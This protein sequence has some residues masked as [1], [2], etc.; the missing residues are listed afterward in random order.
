MYAS[1]N[2]TSETASPRRSINPDYS[3]SISTPPPQQKLSNKKSLATPSYLEEMYNRQQAEKGLN[4]VASYDNQ[5][6]NNNYS[7]KTSTNGDVQNINMLS[8]KNSDRG[9]S[10]ITREK[11]I[12]GA[13]ISQ[14]TRAQTNQIPFQREEHESRLSSNELKQ[15]NLNYSNATTSNKNKRVINK[16]NSFRQRDNN[17]DTAM[18]TRPQDASGLN[19]SSSLSPNQAQSNH[20]RNQTIS[21]SRSETNTNSGSMNGGTSGTK[22]VKRELWWK[23]P[24]PP[25]KIEIITQ[26]VE[27]GNVT[28]R[29]DHMNKNYSPSRSEKK[30]ESRKLEWSKQPGFFL[31]N[32]AYLHDPLVYPG[33]SDASKTLQ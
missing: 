14:T 23:E 26:K 27:L 16:S 11:T 21:P 19:H 2:I 31:I 5:A 3:V 6:Q 25:N 33:F 12:L 17:N 8:T 9:M 7:S 15:Q 30:I 4:G 18:R 10:Q 22:I 32:C 20:H 29:V 24:P 13:G 28:S 1:S